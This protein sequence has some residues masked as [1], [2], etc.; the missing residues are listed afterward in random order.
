LEAAD[1]RL[2]V[3]ELRAAPP[4]R[5]IPA[6]VL[7]SDKCF[8]FVPG[9]GGAKATCQAWRAAHDHLATLLG[10]KHITDTNSGHFIQGEQP[11]LVI[12]AIRQ[13]VDTVRNQ[14]EQRHWGCRDLMN[15]LDGRQQ[16]VGQDLGAQHSTLYSTSY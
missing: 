12:D 6:V 13:V 10:A 8:E 3:R 14:R 16:E 5:S 7:T 11:Q 1:Y 4:V 9:A 2:S 15:G